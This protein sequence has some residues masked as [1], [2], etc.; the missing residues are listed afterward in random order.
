MNIKKRKKV[1]KE[2]VFNGKFVWKIIF[3]IGVLAVIL[4]ER[5]IFE[6]I[7]GKECVLYSVLND[8]INVFGL[9][10]LGSVL[11]N[12]VLSK[13]SFK[14][15]CIDAATDIIRYKDLSF[16]SPKEIA[17]FYSS[18]IKNYLFKDK[19]FSEK[20]T[21]HLHRISLMEESII[22]TFCSLHRESILMLKSFHT[23]TITIDN[24]GAKVNAKKKEVFCMPIGTDFTYVRNV[25]ALANTSSETYKFNRILYNDVELSLQDVLEKKD[26]PF[27]K[28]KIYSNY[29]HP[30]VLAI[31][32]DPTKTEHVVE[33]D[34]EYRTPPY[35]VF[36][37]YKVKHYCESV[38]FA[39]KL[40]D[41]RKNPKFRFRIAAEIFSPA[42]TASQMPGKNP[43]ETFSGMNDTQENMTTFA[44]AP[45]L[46]ME[47]GSGYAIT[48]DMIAE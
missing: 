41:N 6:L 33:L 5:N 22:N 28:T 14:Q 21:K 31:K 9:T 45:G 38:A 47:P 23:I 17:G 25:S 43:A 2:T 24:E 12:F 16:F 20:D 46:W 30:Y 27:Y 34:S 29:E 7:S 39:V 18:S 37:S 3:G 35:D 10:L 4:S 1:F 48:L 26:S 44:T 36:I 42:I 13:S 32:F 8:L 40:V 19:A 11:F 15:D